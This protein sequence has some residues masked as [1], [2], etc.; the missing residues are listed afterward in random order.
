M[1]LLCVICGYEIAEI[2]DPD[3]PITGAMFTSKDPKHKVPAPWS[4][5][6]TWEHM[7]CPMCHK[8]A[9]HPPVDGTITLRT[10]IGNIVLP[11]KTA[12]LHETAQLHFAAMKSNIDVEKPSEASVEQIRPEVAIPTPNIDGGQAEGQGEAIKQPWPEPFSASEIFDELMKF[13]QI[14]NKGGGWYS[15]QGKNRK[16]TEIMSM[17]SGK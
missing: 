17:I 4:P 8:R 7:W 15:Y 3:Y 11:Q 5:V 13:G 1:K 10:N 12:S 14:V 6:L 16:K 2:R 9:M